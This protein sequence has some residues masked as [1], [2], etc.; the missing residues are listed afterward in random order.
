M[1]VAIVVG[2]RPQ[3]VKL[4]PLVAAKPE[5]VSLT[6]L[7]TGQ[8]YSPEMGEPGVEHVK[9]IPDCLMKEYGAPNLFDMG[10]C[11]MQDLLEMKPDWVL[12]I[13]DCR[14]TLAGALAAKEL[15]LPLAHLEAGLRC[16]APTRE[17]R[18]RI[19]VDHHSDLCLCPTRTAVDNLERERYAGRVTW[20]GDIL[21]DALQGQR[22]LC[23]I[24]REENDPHVPAILAQIQGFDVTWVS[25][26][27]N[28]AALAEPGSVRVL[29]PQTQDD[30]LLLM[31]RSAV[32]VTDSGGVSREA[33]LLGKPVLL[34]RDSYEF[35]ELRES[36]VDS[37]RPANLGNKLWS[38][39][40]R[41]Q[42]PLGDGKTAGRV[43]EV[44][45]G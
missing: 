34:V 1:N 32:V 31:A 3:F 22:V 41:A 24:H 11:L 36:D 12:V 10:D 20:V 8:H 21:V 26:P 15:N 44:L 28:V 13:G 23:T 30:L 19:A 14:S 45:A 35:P 27:R 7:H 43:W 33:A 37:A 25:H 29:P 42:T 9:T 16:H 39:L 5:G 2:T 17:E 38:A 6:V 4:R 18:I 40:K